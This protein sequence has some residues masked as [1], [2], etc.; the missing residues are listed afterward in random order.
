MKFCPNCNNILFPKNK[1]LFCKVCSKEY[2]I[3]NTEFSE[4][5]IKRAIKHNEHEL[6]PIIIRSMNN[7]EK[8]SHYYRKAFEDYFILYNELDY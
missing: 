7:R 4:Y 8:I 1:K 3:K 6:S 5:V 2:G